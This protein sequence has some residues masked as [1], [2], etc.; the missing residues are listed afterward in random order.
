MQLWTGLRERGA[1]RCARQHCKRE[2]A[3]RLP[4]PRSRHGLEA[5]G[6]PHCIDA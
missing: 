5:N 4:L 3:A 2:P 6:Q 1:K